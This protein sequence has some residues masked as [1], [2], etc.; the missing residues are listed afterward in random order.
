M[1]IRKDDNVLVISGKDKGKTW[2]VLKVLT[3]TGKIVVEWVNIVTRNFKKSWANP[4][5]SLKKEAALD[6]S[7]TMFICPFTK[8]P[9]RIWF[10][11]VE[12]KSGIKKFR[13]SKVAVKVKWWENKDYIIK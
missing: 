3:K 5:Q 13:F 11:F 6:I 8:K 12:D 1:K 9:T 4:W 10:V 2:K 7:N